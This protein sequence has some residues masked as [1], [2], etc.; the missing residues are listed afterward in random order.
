MKIA[1]I[2][3]TSIT[4]KS[5]YTLHV[6]KMCDAFSKN[7]DLILMIPL[8]KNNLSITKIK[9]FFLLSSKKKFKIKSMLGFKASN[10]IYRIFF[11]I[12][13][14]YN[15]KNN[16]IN[17]IITR[18]ILTSFFLSLFKIHH[19]LEIHSEMS[20]LTKILMI[21]LN[22]INSKYIKKIIFI[23]KSLRKIFNIENK[24]KII[25]L[26]DAVDIKNFSQKKK[27]N[28][29]K[30]L[31]YTGSF[32]KGK[33]VELIIQ[34]ANKFSNL[35]FNLYG[36]PLN[37]SYN[38][39]KNVRIHGYINYNKV[40]SKLLDSDL[41]YKLLNAGVPSHIYGMRWIRLLMGREFIFNQAKN[42]NISN[43]NS[44]L[45]LFEY[46]AAGRIIVSSKRDGISEIL[47][48][49]YNSIIVNGFEVKDWEKSIHDIINSKY[50]L[51]KIRINSIK[52][53][54]NFTWEKRAKMIINSNHN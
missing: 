33:G 12:K 47:K 36:E 51:N 14:S 53:A 3:E 48:H 2:A 21:N 31:T 15:L 52:T 37:K 26:H 5:A 18:S 46:L 41:S 24:K 49:N 42:I 50:K 22:F 43:Y 20:G 17:L 25:I 8:F 40:P 32:H 10:F 28:K 7:H 13:T 9:N 44:P 29:I 39:P 4:N 38:V 19:L 35:T 45:K 11:S 16:N 30:N 1:Y 27:T 54:K 23:S 34:L 6:L